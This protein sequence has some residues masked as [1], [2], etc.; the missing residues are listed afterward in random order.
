MSAA[1]APCPALSV[2]SQAL[3]V[4]CGQ[5]LPGLPQMTPEMLFFL[6]GSTGAA[7]PVVAAYMPDDSRVFAFDGKSYQMSDAEWGHY[8]RL[9][10]NAAPL[11]LDVA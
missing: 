6:S 10:L 5:A 11:P 2:L 7:L 4:A 3:C 9:R 1:A 8:L